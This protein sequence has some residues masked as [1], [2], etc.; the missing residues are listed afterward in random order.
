MSLEDIYTS[1]AS[2]KGLIIGAIIILIVI[3]CFALPSG[4]SRGKKINQEVFGEGDTGPLEKHK[5]A[6][7]IA[8]RTAPHP[9]TP[10]V[11]VYHLVFEL[12]NGS[13]KDFGIRDEQLYSTSMEG[14]CGTIQYIGRKLISFERE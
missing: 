13:R 2:G 3:F 11:T 8:K 9:A 7:L 14:D 1:D 6:K 5:N 10:T 4:I 12:E